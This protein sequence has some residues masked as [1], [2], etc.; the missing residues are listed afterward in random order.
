MSTTTFTNIGHLYGILDKGISHLKGREMS[1]V[2]HLEK[3][4]LQIR[5]GKIIDFGLMEEFKIS[6]GEVIDL[7]GKSIIPGFCDSHT[8]IVFAE[9]REGEWLQRHQGA[10]YEEIANAGGGI[11]NSALK[12]QKMSEEELY[13][14]AAQRLEEVIGL[15]TTAIEIKSG[16]GLTLESEL[17]MLRVIKRLK[18]NYPLLIK[19]TF[20]GA[21][22]IPQMYKED[23][24]AYIE[25]IIEQM[26]PQ[27]VQE[28]L[29]DYCDVFCDKGFFTV[30]ETDLILKAA[31]KLGLKA[32]IHANELANSGGVQVGIKNRAISVDHLEQIGPAEI[33]TLLSSSTLPT[34]LP[35]CSFFLG[36]PYAPCR[37]MIDQGLPVVLA[38]DFNPGS[39][40]SGNMQFVATLA[41]FRMGLMP[42][43]VLNACTINGAHAMELSS[44]TG[45]I[46]RGKRADF[47]IC[48]P[49]RSLS[50]LPYKFGSNIVE[51]T[52]IA[53]TKQRFE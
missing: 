37:K 18:D 43:E 17:K 8:H 20:L 25:E 19:S 5:Q 42:E 2:N 44:V 36:I 45:S 41:S 7:D 3:A 14:S 21:H 51:S 4:Y 53:G 13:E 38:S 33:E 49:M 26:L 1:T 9:N 32:K 50:L 22:A 24:K 46:T 34:A 48:R 52:Y 31:A 27:V 23:R 40:P 29:A 10:S 11:L 30:E 47:L 39:S 12:L 35:S 28:G 6:E 16:Y 15:G